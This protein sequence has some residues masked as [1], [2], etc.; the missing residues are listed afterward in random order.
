MFAVIP[1]AAAITGQNL[2]LRGASFSRGRDH[3][4]P[5]P[6]TAFLGEEQVAWS[7]IQLRNSEAVWRVIAADMPIGLLVEPVVTQLSDYPVG[8]RQL[9]FL[10][11]CIPSLKFS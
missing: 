8:A 7:P 10:P 5:G 6:E 2:G 4:E 1:E 11:Q 3:T 9:A